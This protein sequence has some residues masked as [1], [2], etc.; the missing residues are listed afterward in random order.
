[1]A[2]V[3]ADMYIARCYNKPYFEHPLGKPIGKVTKFIFGFTLMVFILVLIAGPMLLF[4]N[5]NP[6][7][8]TNPVI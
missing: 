4:S 8:V 3:H 6:A 5:I 7:S 2:Q 1:M